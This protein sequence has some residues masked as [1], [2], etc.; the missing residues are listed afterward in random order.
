MYYLLVVVVVVGTLAVAGVARALKGANGT[1]AL[2]LPV[3]QAAEVTARAG[4]LLLEIVVGFSLGLD[5]RRPVPALV[6]GPV[7][8][9]RGGGSGLGGLWLDARRPVALT[10]LLCSLVRGPVALDV[11]FRALMRRPVAVGRGGGSILDDFRFDVR[12]VVT[13]VRGPVALNVLF[14]ALMRGPV[15]LNVLFRAL[16]RGPVALNIL[17]RALMRR[18]GGGILSGFRLDARGPVALSVLF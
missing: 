1:V 10:V 12:P 15:A 6:R 17:F 11:L 2:A 3:Y 4:S 16:M 5:V 18:A 14:R 8:V 9:G 7:T 13:L